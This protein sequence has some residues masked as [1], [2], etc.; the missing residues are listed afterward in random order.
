MVSCGSLR[1]LLSAGVP[2]AQHPWPPLRV[3]ASPVLGCRARAAW[4]AGSAFFGLGWLTLAWPGLL[5]LG[6]A[7]LAW[8]GLLPLGFIGLLA[9]LVPPGFLQ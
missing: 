6:L 8:L 4:L 2:R 1:G 3:G 9:R 5:W 7:Q